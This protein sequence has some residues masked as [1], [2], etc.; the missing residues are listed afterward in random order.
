[1]YFMLITQVI[2]EFTSIILRCEI[3][4]NKNVADIDII[5]WCIFIQNIIGSIGWKI[6]ENILFTIKR[7]F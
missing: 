2:S 1:M 5:F 3:L 6:F 7:H 4:S